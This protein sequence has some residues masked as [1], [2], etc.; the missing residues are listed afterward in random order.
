MSGGGERSA[1]SFDDNLG[2]GGGGMPGGMFGGL[3]GMPGGFPRQD[4]RQHRKGPMKKTETAPSEITRPLKVKLED[5]FAGTT[6]R[7]KITRKLLSGEQEERVIEIDISPGYKAGTKI[8]FPH[9][10]NEREGEEAQ[11]LVFVV[12]EAPHDKFTR[13]GNDLNTTE[14]LPLVDALTGTGSTRTITGLDGKKI[15]VPVP[16][17][18]V[19]PGAQTK[20]SGHGMP[21]RKEGQVRSRGDL[22][23]K[24]DIVFPDRLSV[25]Q[26][27]AIRA[28]LI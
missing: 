19:K 11:D 28:A 18:V 22:I 6:K 4:P 12:E 13:E 10:G 14:K 20:I 15:P 5:L 21:I 1:F 24:W 27:D 2:F 23:V 7:L 17:P 9:A 26:R 16:A 8:R 25:A 3:G